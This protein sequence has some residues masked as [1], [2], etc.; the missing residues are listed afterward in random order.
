MPTGNQYLVPAPS[1]GTNNM[2]GDAVPSQTTFNR[3]IK[4]TLNKKRFNE[5]L[6]YRLPKKI[7][8][9]FSFQCV[10]ACNVEQSHRRLSCQLLIILVWALLV[11][12]KFTD[13]FYDVSYVIAFYAGDRR[14]IAKR[15]M[16]LLYTVSDR[17]IESLV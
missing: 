10:T 3:L 13:E 7:C 4:S 11:L 17:V 2:T 5:E 15:P 9:L 14:H 16:V 12:L 8:D 1:S 6:L